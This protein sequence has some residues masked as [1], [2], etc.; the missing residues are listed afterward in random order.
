MAIES[1]FE[2]SKR[3]LEIYEKKCPCCGEPAFGCHH[4]CPPNDIPSGIQ[5]NSKENLFPFCPKCHD[6]FHESVRK[7]EREDLD[8]L[9]ALYWVTFDLWLS[10]KL[11]RD[12]T[13]LN[14]KTRKSKKVAKRGSSR[15]RIC[16]YLVKAQ[17]LL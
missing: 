5:Y 14:R 1:Y 12:K 6:S 17:D 2:N 11:R 16:Q 3:V 9:I 15:V 10:R 4:L 8:P 7:K 13:E